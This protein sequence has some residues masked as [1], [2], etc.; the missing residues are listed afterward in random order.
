MERVF[1][2]IGCD[3]EHQIIGDNQEAVLNREKLHSVFGGRE[4]WV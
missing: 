3:P 4:S 1:Q 2:E